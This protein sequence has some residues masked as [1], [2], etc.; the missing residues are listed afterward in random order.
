VTDQDSIRIRLQEV[1]AG[2]QAISK[3]LE[4]ATKELG[5]SQTGLD[6]FLNDVEQVR[7]EIADLL[8]ENI[9]SLTDY[10]QLQEELKNAKVQVHGLRATVNQTSSAIKKM[11]LAKKQLAEEYGTLAKNLEISKEVVLP[12]KV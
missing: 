8:R 3:R 1:Y 12:F 5:I 9:I 6:T 7:A 10:A 11:N 2:L 4:T